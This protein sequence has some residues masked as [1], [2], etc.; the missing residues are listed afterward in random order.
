M[1]LIIYGD[2]GA[3]IPETGDYPDMD[4]LVRAVRTNHDITDEIAKLWVDDKFEIETYK[5]RIAH[6]TLPYRFGMYKRLKN[7]AE[8]NPDIVLEDPEPQ[9]DSTSSENIDKNHKVRPIFPLDD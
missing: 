8:Y 6:L 7:R 9:L 5:N 4:T 3:F 2:K 1:N